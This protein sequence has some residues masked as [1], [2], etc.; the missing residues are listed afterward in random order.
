MGE[1]VKMIVPDKQDQDQGKSKTKF[2]QFS[3]NLVEIL[4][5]LLNDGNKYSKIF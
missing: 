3:S 2:P 4:R 5:G 1:T